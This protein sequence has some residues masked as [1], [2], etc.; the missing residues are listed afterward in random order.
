MLNMSK[1]MSEDLSCYYPICREYG[2]NGILEIKINEDFTI[3]CKCENNEKH[4]NKGILFKIFETYYLKKKEIQIC[5]KCKQNLENN[6]KYKCLHCKNIYCKDCLPFD[7]HIKCDKNN[8]MI[9]TGKCQ[10]HHPN[11]LIYYCF[12]CK[13]ALCHDCINNT[14]K[15]PHENHKIKYIMDSILSNNKINSLFNMIEQKKLMYQ[16]LI[17]SINRWQEELVKKIN[18]LKNN[19]KEELNLLEKM[20]YSYNPYFTNYTYHENYNYLHNNM[21]IIN[22]KDL[23]NFVN[24]YKF[25]EQTKYIMKVLL[26][27]NKTNTKYKKIN[28]FLESKD[29]GCHEKVIKINSNFFLSYSSHYSGRHKIKMKLNEYQKGNIYNGKE[30]NFNEAIYSFSSSKDKTKIY[31][32]LFDKKAIRIFNINLNNKTIKISEDEINE[33]KNFTHYHF[34][35]CIEISEQNLATT[36]SKFIKIWEKNQNG[37]GYLNKKTIQLNGAN[38]LLLINNDCFMST[39]PSDNKLIFFDN[40]TLQQLGNPVK[41]DFSIYSDDC[42]YLI[43]DYVIIRGNKGIGLLYIKTKEYVQYIEGYDSDFRICLDEFDNIYFSECYY[44]LEKLTIMKLKMIDGLFVKTKEYFS[45][46]KESDKIL[47]DDKF[48]EIFSIEFLFMDKKDFVIFINDNIFTLKKLD[49]SN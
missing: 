3:N 4:F 37:K 30:I 31:A 14:E 19:L 35:K 38:D 33:H 27:K 9:I 16:K 40:N 22:N 24:E 25:D 39:V 49:D 13:K 12:D 45:L 11:Q 36:E 43:K 2:C 32:C 21:K 8:L 48:S 20:I 17:D 47:F 15:K 34:Y 41:V 23:N 18:I 10:F 1:S 42:L 5:S 29:D 7:K 28:C 26:K 46:K 44:D 6:Y